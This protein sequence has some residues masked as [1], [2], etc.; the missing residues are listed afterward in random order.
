MTWSS[1]G[2]TC[3]HHR[4]TELG[5]HEVADESYAEFGVI[6]GKK[7]GTYDNSYN[8]EPKNANRPGNAEPVN[9]MSA[10]G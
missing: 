1:T 2:R 4:Y 8:I 5:T 7:Q 10:K 3:I 6:E 9:P